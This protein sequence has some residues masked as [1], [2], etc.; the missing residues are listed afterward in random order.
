MVCDRGSGCLAGPC[1]GLHRPTN[2]LSKAEAL[3]KM[4]AL[5]PRENKATRAGQLR[6]LNSLSSATT[7][8]APRQNQRKTTGA[9][10]PR[11][12][13]LPQLVEILKVLGCSQDIFDSVRSKV[14]EKAKAKAKT[15]PG[16][17][18]VMGSTKSFA[19]KCNGLH[20]CPRHSHA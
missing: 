3:G 11:Q 9:A 20:V 8:S 6:D 4:P 13:V 7:F 16:E 17:K 12:D 18:E 10:P 14:E 15:P 2:G 1:I 5:S 19:L